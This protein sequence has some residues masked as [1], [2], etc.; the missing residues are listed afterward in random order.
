MGLCGLAV[1]LRNG[2][3]CKCSFCNRDMY[4]INVIRGPNQRPRFSN[5]ELADMHLCYGEAR[6]NAV[7][8]KQIYENKFP[9]RHQPDRRL[10]TSLH[11][12]LR[13]TGSLQVS[14]FWCFC[15]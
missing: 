14:L 12:R 9:N 8:G 3:A 11:T 13:T 7:R 6:G 4:R 2:R 5:V 15:Y 1:E 10:F